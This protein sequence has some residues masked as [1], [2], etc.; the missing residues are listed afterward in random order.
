MSRETVA[1][2]MLLILLFVL[3]VVVFWVLGRGEYEP[4]SPELI[5]P[6]F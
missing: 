2:G 6:L 4:P 3:F 5:P 1:F